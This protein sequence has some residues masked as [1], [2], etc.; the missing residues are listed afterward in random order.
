MRSMQST[1]RVR[2]SHRSVSMFATG[3]LYSG[4][5]PLERRAPPQPE[6]SRSRSDRTRLRLRLPKDLARIEEVRHMR[7]RLLLL[8]LFSMSVALVVPPSATGFYDATKYA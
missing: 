8:L 4:L 1:W 7:S 2:W 6:A 5:F 3:N